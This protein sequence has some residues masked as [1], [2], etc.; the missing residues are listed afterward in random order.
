MYDN[1]AMDSYMSEE[2]LE[3]AALMKGGSRGRHQR[4]VC[5]FHSSKILRYACQFMAGSC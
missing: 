5:S 3:S 2:S 1:G 4:K